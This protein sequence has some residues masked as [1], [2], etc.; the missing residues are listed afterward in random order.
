MTGSED[1]VSD[2]APKSCFSGNGCMLV[3]QMESFDMISEG[4]RQWPGGPAPS[5]YQSRFP[6]SALNLPK[7]ADHKNMLLTGYMDAC[8]VWH[9]QF[10]MCGVCVGV[11]VCVSMC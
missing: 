4:N 7:K 6:D 3:P 11:Y 5:E 2:Q 9:L 1:T 10:C 8:V